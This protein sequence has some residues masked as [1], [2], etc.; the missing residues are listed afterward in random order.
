V[1]IVIGGVRLCRRDIVAR[2]QNHRTRES[3]L[4]KKRALIGAIREQ[5]I[6]SSEAAAHVGT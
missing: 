6:R 3:E 1:T 5:A 2:R 4:R